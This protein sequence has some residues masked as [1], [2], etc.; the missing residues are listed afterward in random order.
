[1]SLTQHL[2]LLE[3]DYG[4]ECGWF[5]ECDG[6]KL[7]RLVDPKMEEMYWYSYRMEP[8][9][10]DPA[11]LTRLYSNEFWF[12]EQLMYRNCEFNVVADFAFAGGG[13][14]EKQLRES[15]RILMRALYL[16]T[17]CFPWDHVFLWM[18]RRWHKGS[19]RLYDPR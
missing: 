15:G 3:T 17:I 8:L 14:A 11:D 18:R 4:R 2:R 13:N 1:M 6:R 7:A 12:S 16:N 19:A 5:V 10:D 9:S